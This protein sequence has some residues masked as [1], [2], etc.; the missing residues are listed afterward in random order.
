MDLNRCYIEEDLFPKIFASYEE[1]PY[2]VLFYNSENKDSYDSNH[3]VI[4][5]DKTHDLQAVLKDIIAFYKGKGTNAIIYQSMLDDGYFEEIKDEFHAAG[6]RSW[7]EEQKYMLPLEENKI[8]PNNKVCVRKMDGWEDSLKQIFIEAEETWEIQVV[9]HSM[10]NVDAWMFAAYLEDK[11]IGLIYGH[12]N[13]D[14]C[15]VDYL[16]VSKKHRCI[17]AGR[18]LFSAYVDWCR[19][20]EI[21]NAYLWPDGDT[22]EKIYIEGG[23]R[24]IE[25]RKAGRAVYNEGRPENMNVPTF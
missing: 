16:I 17:G 22:P 20:N 18:A 15:R 13:G 7:S 8:A 21:K 12:A 2:G 5:R 4:Y 11:P 24:L 14:V 23:Y 10:K 19:E 9:K 25:V 6:F 3:A 1:K